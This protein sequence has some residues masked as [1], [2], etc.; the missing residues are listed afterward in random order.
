MVP[1]A[2]AC[3]CGAWLLHVR[4]HG[5][6]MLEFGAAEVGGGVV[7]GRRRSAGVG[8]L[9]GYRGRGWLLLLLL[10]CLLTFLLRVV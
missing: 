10:R 1:W 7:M 2:C 9:G 3:A 5:A 4:L 6:F 8:V